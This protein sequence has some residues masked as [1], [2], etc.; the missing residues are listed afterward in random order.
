MGPETRIVKKIMIRLRSKWPGAYLRKIHGSMYQHNG[1]PDIIGCIKGRFI[2][3]EVKTTEGHVSLIQVLEGKEIEA[4]KGLYAVV[5]NADE[6][7]EAVKNHLIQST[8]KRRP[9]L[10]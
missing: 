3:L 7:E 1:I 5:T 2:S 4:N 6:A 8:S 10:T 9:R